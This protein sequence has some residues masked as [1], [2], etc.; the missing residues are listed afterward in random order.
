MSRETGRRSETTASES[1]DV[2]ASRAFGKY[3][4]IGLQ[5]AISVLLFLYAGQWI[6]RRLHTAPWGVLG[7]VLVGASA[8]FYSMY[9]RLM[10]DLERDEQARRRL[11]D[12]S[13]SSPEDH[14]QTGD[15]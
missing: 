2:R 5:F 7:G 8:A 1:E 9:R 13:A 14:E 6:D 15:T 11:R 12:A 4:G 10:A 3:A